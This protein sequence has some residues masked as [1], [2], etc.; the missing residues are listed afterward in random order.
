MKPVQK[1]LTTVLWALM[2][3]LMVSIIGA[4]MW[5]RGN[6]ADALTDIPTTS[7]AGLMV[8][9]DAPHFELVDQNDKPVTLESLSGKP[10]IADF[11]FTHCAGPCPMMTAKMAQLQKETPAGVRLVS[12]SVDP[13]RDTPAVLKEYAAKFKADESRWSFLTGKP[14]AIFATARG[15]LIAAQ[16]A[17]ADTPI[18]HSEKFVLVDASGKIRKFYDS[19]DS[20]SMQA[21]TADAN[22]LAT[23]R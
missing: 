15:M 8:V 1:A 19:N 7:P 22:Q 11:V 16:P 14:D 10:W 6:R 12:F 20:E 2:V 9:G 5:R 13:E 17:Q 4:G 21:L 18:I 3:L 23:E